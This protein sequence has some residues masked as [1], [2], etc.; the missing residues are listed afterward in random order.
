MNTHE[1]TNLSFVELVQRARDLADAR[2]RSILGITGAP[3]AGKSTLA[4]RLVEALGSETSVFVPMDGFHLANRVL[5]DLGRLERKGALDTFDGWGYANLL[6]RLHGQRDAIAEGTDGIVYAPQFRRDLEE[7]IGSA[8]PVSPEIP[9]IVTE[10]NYLLHD[11]GPWTVARSCIDEVWFLAPSED[12][13]MSRLVERHMQFGR[14]A[15]EARERSYGSDQRNAELIQSTA[16]RANLVVRLT[17][18][19]S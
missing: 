11:D 18:T 1:A 4:E 8:L 12:I 16:S 19:F 9:L 10:G 17:D 3:G 7:P 13:R 2:P 15:D 14:N 6:R 5:I